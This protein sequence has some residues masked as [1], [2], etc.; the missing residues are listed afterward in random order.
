VARARIAV[1]AAVGVGL[2]LAP[3]SGSARPLTAPHCVAAQLALSLTA[4]EAQMTGEHGSMFA[5]RNH[6]RAACSLLGYPRVRLLDGRG[7]LPFRYGYGTG[8]YVPRLRPRRVV[9]RPGRSAFVLVV[10]YRC[11]RGGTRAATRIEVTP[12][13]GRAPLA[14]R[15][16]AHRPRDYEYCRG[17][18]GDPG[19]LLQIS[20]VVATPA[21]LT[22][23]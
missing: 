20:P 6:G 5:L 12:P 23:G 13:G 2:V 14:S 18:R 16:I 9:L 11:D 15:R 4:Y 1:L 21:Q 10:K 8:S 19:N 3:A 22:R 17:G 7:V